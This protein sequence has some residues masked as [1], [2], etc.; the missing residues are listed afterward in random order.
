MNRIITPLLG[1]AVVTGIAALAVLLG[2]HS[3]PAATPAPAPVISTP[4]A[5]D[6]GLSDCLTGAGAMDPV[7]M[8]RLPR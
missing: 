7:C 4:A 3:A 6:H 1:G 8:A 5:S 2:A